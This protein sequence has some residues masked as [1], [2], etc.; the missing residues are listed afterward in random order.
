MAAAVGVTGNWKNHLTALVEAGVDLAVIDT[1]HGRARLVSDAVAQ[2]KA[3]FPTLPI[4]AGSVATPEGTL[5]LID[6][7]ADAVKVGVG[8]GSI[9][10]F[11]SS[12]EL[13]YHNWRLCERARKQRATEAHQPSLMAVFGS[14]ATS[15]RHWHPGGK[16]SRWAAYWLALTRP[17]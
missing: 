15:S 13:A 12:P 6:A 11:T 16:R 4:I 9:C 17:R 5:A 7:G 8:A 3:L 10:T 14:P 2:A 1:A